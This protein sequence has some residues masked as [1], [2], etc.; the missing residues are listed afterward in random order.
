MAQYEIY[1]ICEHCKSVHPM[2]TQIDIDNGPTDTQS[3]DNFYTGKD[4]PENI[5][6]LLDD[7]II[8]PKTKKPL[9]QK[10]NSRAFIVPIS[11]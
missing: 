1:V 9:V 4:F 10:D 2:N 3:I 11:D 5:A 7:L 6:L 8:C